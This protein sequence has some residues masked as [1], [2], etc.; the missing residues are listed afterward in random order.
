M[1]YKVFRVE[2]G[3][4]EWWVAPNKEQVI[5]GMDSLYGI[6]EEDLEET[7]ITELS[8]E[9]INALEIRNIEEKDEPLV[10]ARSMIEDAFS[11]EAN[12]MPFQL[13]STAY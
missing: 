3:E 9:E 13:A 11:K 2:N 6:D 12:P 5:D 10:S 4:T 1:D 8:D 7:E